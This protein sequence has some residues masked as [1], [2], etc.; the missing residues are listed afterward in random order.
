MLKFSF[1]YSLEFL[2]LFEKVLIAET[3]T[4]DNEKV[5]IRWGVEEVMASDYYKKIKED[6]QRLNLEFNKIIFEMI[7]YMN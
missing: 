7:E 2:E 3:R 4:I 1:N 6:E 5:P